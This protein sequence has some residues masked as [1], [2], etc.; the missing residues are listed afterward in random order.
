MLKRKRGKEAGSE[1]KWVKQWV[2]PEE[3]QDI[4]SLRQ[5]WWA[6]CYKETTIMYTTHAKQWHERNALLFKWLSSLNKRQEFQAK[7]PRDTGVYLQFL[8][9]YFLVC[10]LFHDFL[11]YISFKGYR[12]RD[13][14]D[15]TTLQSSI[16]MH[17]HSFDSIFQDSLMMKQRRIANHIEWRWWSEKREKTKSQ[18]KCL[19]HQRL[20][21]KER[22][23]NHSR[24]RRENGLRKGW[25]E[26]IKRIQ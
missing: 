7:E 16:L 3:S 11:F 14:I 25:Q 22:G 26:R 20:F 6:N 1:R 4:E 9:V 24:V 8:L 23:R 18:V 17:S 19:G 13:S 2:V 5:R 10:L 12:L 21:I 15:S